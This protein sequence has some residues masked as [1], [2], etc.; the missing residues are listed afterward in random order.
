MAGRD[1]VAPTWY[2]ARKG[3][4]GN[5]DLSTLD[6]ST[7]FRIDGDAPWELVGNS[8]AGVGD[9]NGD[10]FDDLLLGSPPDG[11][12]ATDF[13]GNAYVVFGGSR[14]SSLFN[15][16]LLHGSNGFRIQARYDGDALGQSV[17][18]AGDFNHDGYADLLLGSW[19]VN[20]FNSREAYVIYGG[21]SGF[22]THARP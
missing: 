19:M 22:P 11:V 21:P 6:G 13:D 5:I 15:V 17:S 1:P 14:W 7:G 12:N 18:G 2:S 8:V 10:G 20:G 9:V 16:G 3:G 4:I